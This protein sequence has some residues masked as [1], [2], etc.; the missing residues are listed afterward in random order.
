MP[1]ICIPAFQSPVSI[2]LMWFMGLACVSTGNHVGDKGALA[3]SDGLKSNATL[4]FL[5]LWHNEVGDDGALALSKALQQNTALRSI[6]LRE[7]NVTDGGACAL[8]E[9]LMVNTTLMALD[10]R[11]NPVG[12]RGGW[13]LVVAWK[14]NPTL[15]QLCIHCDQRLLP[16]ESADAALQFWEKEL[17]AP[18]DPMVH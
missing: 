1:R 6:D 18:G 9:V 13:A 4:Q 17:A 7:G 5:G 11:L 16:F 14:A 2:V 3:L 8:A 12:V 15:E 10:L